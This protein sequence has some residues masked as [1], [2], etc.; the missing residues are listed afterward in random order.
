MR[1]PLAVVA[2]F[3]TQAASRQADATIGVV[4]RARDPDLRSRLLRCLLVDRRPIV[5]DWRRHRRALA[6]DVHDLLGL[7]ARSWGAQDH[8]RSLSQA[9][10]LDAGVDFGLRRAR[11]CDGFSPALSRVVEFVLAAGLELG[12]C[13]P[14]ACGSDLRVGTCRRALRLCFLASDHVTT[15]LARSVFRH[16]M[17]VVVR[18]AARLGDPAVRLESLQGVVQVV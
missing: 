7:G 18:V 11:T 4:G 16:A 17:R 15:T 12:R 1:V 2:G 13:W 8:A 14:L 3:P 6:D 5:L 10:A 9:D